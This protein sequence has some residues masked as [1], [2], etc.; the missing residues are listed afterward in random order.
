MQPPP[1]PQQQSQVPVPFAAPGSFPDE[2][3]PSVVGPEFKKEVGLSFAVSEGFFFLHEHGT[4]L[5][6]YSYITIVTI[7]VTLPSFDS[8]LPFRA[9]TPNF[10]LTLNTQ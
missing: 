2:F 9:L 3:D 1:L 8:S 5:I 4:N 6:P 10:P 7:F